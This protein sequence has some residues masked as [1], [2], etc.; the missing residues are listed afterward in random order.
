MDCVEHINQ[1]NIP[2]SIW[3]SVSHRRSLCWFAHHPSLIDSGATK[4]VFFRPS[5]LLAY[6][7][8]TPETVKGAT[9]STVI[10]GKG[11][12]WIS[13]D[14]GQNLQAN[15][16]PIFDPN[17][18]SVDVFDKKIK[19]LFYSSIRAYGKV[20]ISKYVKVQSGYVDRL[21]FF[22][23]PDKLWEEQISLPYSCIWKCWGV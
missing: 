19:V 8:L 22:K 1:I 21:Q 11:L 20:S 10:V 14:G 6:T 16:L 23:C 2:F 12:V 4:N 18:L 9:G 5:E 7:V 13:I 15:N 17:I 3:I